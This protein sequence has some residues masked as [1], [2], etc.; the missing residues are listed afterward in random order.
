MLL[1]VFPDREAYTCKG[2]LFQRKAYLGDILDSFAFSSNLHLVLVF[3]GN[4]LGEV[5]DG[6]SRCLVVLSFRMICTDVR[7]DRGV[8]LSDCFP[9]GYILLE[10]VDKK[11]PVNDSFLLSCL[12]KNHHFYTCRRRRRIFEFM[13][14]PCSILL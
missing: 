13:L 1:V 10:L 2:L 7:H 3:W 4:C 6:R 5:L 11:G 8:L 9:V 12:S 14:V